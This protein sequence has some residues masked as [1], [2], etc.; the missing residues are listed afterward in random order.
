MKEYNGLADKLRDMKDGYVIDLIRTGEY[1]EWN[2]G[3]LAGKI[4]MLDEIIRMIEDE[5]NDII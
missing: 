3:I 5:E 4:D 1:T 2:K